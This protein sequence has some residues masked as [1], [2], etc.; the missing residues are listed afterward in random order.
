MKFTVVLQPEADGG[1][2]VV[3]PAV[4][5]CVSQGDTLDEALANVREAIVLCLEVRNEQ[6]QPAPTETPEIIAEEIRACLKDRADEGLPL[7]IETR[8]V[9]LEAEVAV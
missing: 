2:S 8:E 3:C 1:Y 5:G 4:P 9:E 6:G 7:T